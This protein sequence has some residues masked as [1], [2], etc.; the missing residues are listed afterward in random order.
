LKANLAIRN[1]VMG[2]VVQPER[3]G[4][5]TLENDIFA[6]FINPDSG[7]QVV[8]EDNGRVA[9]GY[10]LDAAEKIIA[11]VWLY[12]RCETPREPEWQTPEML[13][14][15]N[16]MEFAKDHSGFTPVEDASEVIVGWIPLSDDRMRA[17]ISIRGD[18]FG[19]MENGTEPGLSLMAAKDGPLAKV[20]EVFEFE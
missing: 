9:Y 20:L 4:R 16:P 12:N 18:V 5:G 13:P 1:I 6:D 7:Y 10:L 8:F 17:I 2:G 14:F 11:D 3:K 15:A 19:I